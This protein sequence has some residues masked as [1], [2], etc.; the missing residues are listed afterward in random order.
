MTTKYTGTKRV[1]LLS[2]Y[3]GDNE[4]A[5]FQ[6]HTLFHSSKLKGAEAHGDNRQKALRDAYRWRAGRR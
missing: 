2:R 3:E 1:V 5:A 6:L 4:P